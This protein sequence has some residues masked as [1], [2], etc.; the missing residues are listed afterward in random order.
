MASSSL[1]IIWYIGGIAIL[2]T[3]ENF[4][5]KRE[6]KVCSKNIIFYY[7]KF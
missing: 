1:M 2:K 6:M 3:G 4:N 5:F 7:F